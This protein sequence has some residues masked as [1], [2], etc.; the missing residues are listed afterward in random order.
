[1]KKYINL[2]KTGCLLFALG[3]TLSAWAQ[4][5]DVNPVN[6]PASIERIKMESLWF[7]NTSN[8]AG[9]VLDNAA[10]YST[11][12]FDYHQT[13]GTFK[14][15]QEGKR[16]KGF[17]FDTE[18][19]G[20]LNKLK[21]AYVWGNFSYSRDNTKDACYNASLIDPLRGMP[22]ILA[23]TNMSK[24]VNQDFH[25]QMK[26]ASPKIWDRV[27]IGLEGEYRSTIGA[28]QRDPRP[29]VNL[30]MIRMKPGVVVTL[31]KRHAL[32]ANFDYYSRREDGSATNS[33]GIVGQVAWEMVAP[34]FFSEGSI[35][36]TGGI[37]GVR[38]YNANAMG[39]GFQYSLTLNCAKLLLSG[40]Y[41]HKV[42]DAKNSYTKPKLVG[43]VSEDLYNIRLAA[44][45]DFDQTNSL[46]LNARYT[47][48]SIDGIE[49]VQ[50]Y[51]NTYEVQQWIIKAKNI[52]SNFSTQ[53]VNADLTYLIKTEGNGYKWKIG[54][55]VLYEK[56]SDIYYIPKSTQGVEN[57]TANVNLKKNFKLCQFSNLLVGVKAAYNKN[58]EGEHNYTGNSGETKVYNDFVLKDFYYLTTDYVNAGASVTYS[59]SGLMNNRSSVFVGA[60]FDYVK[61][62]DYK[63][64]FNHRTA[65]S[66]SAGLTF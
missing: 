48:R 20:R 4:E 56:L 17:G 32:G 55:G 49:Y 25:L 63:D 36:G 28:K 46:F 2:T 22:F 51:D 13:N 7:G 12:G 40:D 41:M 61:A 10:Y 11:L 34:G 5:R 65:F 38:N 54:A 27:I 6:T 29:E 1:M 58:L 3:Y 24:W 64:L 45:Y 60:T 31:G 57:I 47:D 42:E 16:N 39:A 33:N 53:Q 23:D 35:G 37:S 19:G 15:A 9:S 62:N 66:F 26:V 21:G 30:G 18:G 14:R 43:T 8:A 59:Y 44:I 50:V 52:R